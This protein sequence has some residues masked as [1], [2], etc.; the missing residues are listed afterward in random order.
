MYGFRRW[1]FSM[2]FNIPI[3]RL[4]VWRAVFIYSSIIRVIWN[5]SN[6]RKAPAATGTYK[7]WTNLFMLV[8][9]VILERMSNQHNYGYIWIASFHLNVSDVLHRYHHRSIRGTK[10]KNADIRRRFGVQKDRK[11]TRRKKELAA[12]VEELLNQFDDADRTQ[13]YGGMHIKQW[14]HAYT[15]NNTTWFLSITIINWN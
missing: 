4:F 6:T 12:D 14:L 1:R 10:I 11:T 8:F 13:C 3:W 7:S 15:T 2:F 9:D 5:Q